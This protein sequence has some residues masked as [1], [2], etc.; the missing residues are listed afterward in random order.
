MMARSSASSLLLLLAPLLLLSVQGRAAAEYHFFCPK[1]VFYKPKH[2]RIHYKSICPKPICPGCPLPHFGYT[3]TTW[4][5]WPLP[6]AGTVLPM[7]KTE[8][9][10]QGAAPTNS[11]PLPQPSKLPQ[12]PALP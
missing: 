11:E 5:P 9:G 6:T 1:T 8:T 3:P 10:R 7:S 2:P 4:H 12:E